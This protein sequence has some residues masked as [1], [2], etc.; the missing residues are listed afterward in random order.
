MPYPNFSSPHC[1]LQSLD[2]GSTIEDFIQRE[3]ELG[4]GTITC[5]DH[6]YLGACRE[7]YDL[8]RKNNLKPIIGIEGYHRDDNCQI[9]TK[10]GIKKDNDGTFKTAYKYGHITI[11]A[12]DQ[13]AYQ[14]I[15]KLVSDRDL[16]AEQHG[17]E[18][19]PIFTW[20]DLADLGQYNIT[21]TSGCFIKGTL[22]KTTK[23]L[24]EIQDIQSG[25]FVYDKDGFERKVNIATTREFKGKLYKL[26]IQNTIGEIVCTENHEFLVQRGFYDSQWVRADALEAGNHLQISIEKRPD[27]LNNTFSHTYKNKTT[28]QETT[29]T[30]DLSDPDTLWALGLFVA[31]GSFGGKNPDKEGKD[32]PN[33]INIALHRNKDAEH[34]TRFSNWAIKS[35][36]T[37]VSLYKRKISAAYPNPQGI[38]INVFSR[39][40]TETFLALFEGRTNAEIKHI[41]DC[42]KNLHPNL[43][44]DFIKG[45]MDGDGSVFYKSINHKNTG[46]YNARILNMTT[47]SRQ[48]ADDLLSI[49]RR[50][51]LVVNPFIQKAKKSK[52]GVNHK[53]AYYLNQSGENAEAILRWVNKQVI[54]IN[55]SK[56]FSYLRSIES[57]EYTGPVYCLNVETEPNFSLASGVVVHNCLIGIV[58][59]HVKEG[60]FEIAL[61]YYNKLRSL[62]KPDNFYVE[63][64]T[65]KCDKNWVSGVFLELK[66]GKTL[67]YYFGKKLKTE[68]FE[69][70]SVIDLAKVV[71]KG[72]NPGRLIAI[73][74]YRVWENIEPVE[75]HGCKIVRDFIPN[76]CSPWCP[77]GDIQASV[78]KFLYQVAQKN[79]DP[80]LISDD[81][82]AAGTLIRSDKGY[83]PIE[84][85]LPGDKVV[86]HLGSWGEVEAT[87]GFFSNKKLYKINGRNFNLI[88]TEDHKVWVRPGSKFK[89]DNYKQDFQDP[90]W[91]EVSKLHP[92]FWVFC[93]KSP[94]IKAN[95][96]VPID[97]SVFFTHN[98]GKYV[99]IEEKYIKS[100]SRVSKKENI[101]SRYIYWDNQLATIV[102]L[103]LGDGNAHNNLVSFA[104]DN[105]TWGKIGSIL[106][107]FTKKYGFSFDIKRHPGHVTYRI[108]NSPLTQWFRRSFY[109]SSKVKIPGPVAALPFELRW[110]VMD[111]LLWSD[112]TNRNGNDNDGKV[113][114]SMTSLP[115]I[116]WARELCLANGVWTS[117][118]S[119]R[120]IG[121]T[122]PLYTIDFDHNLF[123]FVSI[124]K[125]SCLAPKKQHCKYT[126]DGYWFRIKSIDLIENSKIPVY[127]L[128]IGGPAPSFSTPVVSVH[129]CHYAKKE[130]RVVQEAKLGGMGDSFKFYGSYHRYSSEEAFKH[131][132]ETMGMS[133]RDFEELLD[134]NARW[135][136][137]FND[138]KL[139][140][141]TSL[142]TSFYPKDTLN[143]LFTLI[144]KHGRMNWNNQEMKDRLN[145]EIN[146][147]KENGTIDLLPYFFL[148]EEVP[149]MYIENGE[150]P[151]PGRGSSAGLLISY[152][153]GITHINPLQYKLSKDRFLTLD[154]IQSNKMPDIDQDLP[155]RDLLIPWLEKRF[156]PNVAQVSTRQLLKIKSG[157]KDV[158]RAEWGNVPDEIEALCKNIPNTPQG[159]EDKDFLFGYTGEDGK[160]VKG[161]F[162]GHVGLQAYAKKYPKQWEVVLKILGIVR[163]HSR[164]ASAY[165]IADKPI[166][167]IVPLMTINGVRATQYTAASCE[168]SGLLK[169]DYLCL[170]T[171]IDLQNAIKIIQERSGTKINDNEIINGIKVPKIF[172]I[173]HKGKLLDIYNLPLDQSVFHT[174]CE[175]ETETV[176]QLNTSSAVK[177]LNEFN[178]W[179]DR[180]EKRKS[181]DSIESVATFTALDRPGPLDAIVSGDGKTRNMLQEYAARARK[182]KPLGP[183]QFLD[184]GLA[185]TFGI[186]IFQEQLQKV[187]QTLTGCSGIEANQFRNDI[188]KK[189]MTK[190]I[191]RFPFFMENASK[192]IG[193][194]EAKKIWEQIYVFGQYGFN[195]SHA[196]SYAVLA[197]SCAYLKHHFPLE[198]WCAVLRNADKNEIGEKFW[199]Y[200][201]EFVQL[202]DIQ[203]SEDKFDIKNGKIVA[204]LSILHGV[205]EGAHLELSENKP[206][207]SIDDF[208]KKI[209]TQK[210]KKTKTLEDG[211]TRLGVSALNR[212]VVSKL[213][214]SGVLDSLFEHGTTDVVAK[215]ELFE[216]RLALALNKKKPEKIKEE[217]RNL[218]SLQ[219]FQHKKSVLPIYSEFLLPYLVDKGVEGI[220][221]KKVKFGEEILETYSYKP[222]NPDTISYINK[223]MGVKDF[224]GPL[225]FV[226]GD[227]LRYMNEDAIIDPDNPL[228]VATACYVLDCRKFSFRGKKDNKMHQACEFVLDVNGEIIKSVKWATKKTDELVLP[229][230]ELKGAIV[231]ASLSRW[232]NDR[233]FSIESIIKVQEPL[234]N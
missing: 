113:N 167:Q 195:L 102:G 196:T 190:V 186:M 38:E 73:K 44:R 160:E 193:E 121:S 181:I 127:D 152:L 221:K 40:L 159:I 202:P 34:V 63:L 137:R 96:I 208:C 168:A 41:P 54:Y 192:I 157:I 72:K 213:I 138:F 228:H 169:M 108:I 203:Y 10:H 163:A 133:E 75:I 200:C 89:C 103:F 107:D 219:V 29:I 172:I 171:L 217:Y 134:N 166:D 231:V 99:I 119:R 28:G 93:P 70:I 6:G 49:L 154:R 161:I 177:W 156:G 65:H 60:N 87:R 198:W 204:P 144:D 142:P 116:S 222:Q 150:L 69:E 26:K 188:G 230:G 111:G 117:F 135:A 8:A 197:Y 211:N 61:D 105:E 13:P 22:V 232:S 84:N 77:D 227:L 52:D 216:E 76:E 86:N 85:L 125:G 48:L 101:Y 201:K 98:N 71:L 33:S 140:N 214:V 4:T 9:L 131:F 68:E 136:S 183:I 224:T 158:A 19:K 31:E 233:G 39:A 132:Q 180:K 225:A 58:G 50:A 17:S 25:D 21:A 57:F 223:S 199:K 189:E 15:V 146:L 182:E 149:T 143:H 20:E 130:D 74:N 79:G 220:T 120:T 67:Q 11:H 91:I 229:E 66:N 100:T 92:G 43:L 53:E 185:E 128:Q 147:L 106:E 176:F 115:V 51:D 37:S 170:N 90:Q 118:G 82:I 7:V 109:S 191:E 45:Y 78:N 55:N 104:I 173:P 30:F 124:W 46:K 155:N 81:C 129:N 112:G 5:T 23:G 141:P 179:K 215:L 32:S 3:K 27:L 207:I 35:G 174:I 162:E 59:R 178:Y 42:I 97:L 164:H 36:A 24:K 148:G 175:G 187:Y 226:D 165:I 210:V 2:T 122:M 47:I 110:K 56:S 218:S 94:I 64:F 212:G 1:H 145:D 114:L 18:R 16:T 80:I 209:A 62:I 14:K 151:G 234:E 194:E 123:K 126:K 184:E 153:L 139:I 95:E 83:I 88:A 206:F 12:L 205:G